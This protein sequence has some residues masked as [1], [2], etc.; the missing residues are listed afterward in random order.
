MVAIL[1]AKYGNEKISH[2]EN[3]SARWVGQKMAV[4]IVSR[5]TTNN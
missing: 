2:V 1:L 3:G 5:L 4:G